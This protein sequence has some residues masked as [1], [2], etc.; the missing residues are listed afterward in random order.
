MEVYHE[1]EEKN[2]TCAAWNKIIRNVNINQ[3]LL[4]LPKEAIDIH[5]L[6][7]RVFYI[8]M[9]VTVQISF[10]SLMK[11]MLMNWERGRTITRELLVHIVY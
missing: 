5:R 3:H 4:T 8:F 9:L 2:S 7:T 11:M 6:A 10:C 1:R